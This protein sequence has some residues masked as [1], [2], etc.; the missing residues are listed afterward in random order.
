[1][2]PP[3]TATPGTSLNAA[4]PESHQEAECREQ[5]VSTSAN[6]FRGRISPPEFVFTPVATAPLSALLSADHIPKLVTVTAPAGY[7][8]TVFMSGLHKALSDREDRCIWIGLDDRDSDLSSLLYL[9]R[10]ALK[11]ADVPYDMEPPHSRENVTNQGTYLDGLL[12]HLSQ[13]D[14]N[15]VLFIDNLG[16]C[17]DTQLGMTLE[18]LIMESGPRLRLVFSTSSEL[19]IDIVRAKLE[20]GAMEL[21]A[22]QLCFDRRCTAQL[23]SSA[24]IPAPS[25]EE[26]DHIQAQT[27]GWPAAVRLLQILMAQVGHDDSADDA[28]R[29]RELKSF[30]GD[31]ND[32]A[33]VLTRRVLIGFERDFLEFLT[34]VAL[35][36]EFSVDLAAYATGHHKAEAWINTLV[37][38][39]ILIFPLDRSRRWYRLH[40]LLREYLLA[41]GR[42]RI[43]AER[44][45]TI[46][47]RA[48]QWHTN[49]G[50]D[51]TAIGIALDAQD[52]DLAKKLVDRVA[53]T[54][55]GDQGQMTPLVHWVDRLLAAGVEP[56]VE[57]HGWYVWALGDNL[58][59]E[60]AQQALDALDRRRGGKSLS[61]APRN[62]LSARLEFLRI[63]LGIYNDR[64]D[65]AHADAIAWLDK[66]QSPDALSTMTIASIAAVAETD[67]G[68]LAT[69]RRHIEIA[70]SAISRSVSGYG[71]AWE[72]IIHAFIDIAEARPDIADGHFRAMRPRVVEL[73]GTEANAVVIF[74]FIH[75]R[76][77]LDMGKA[78]AARPLAMRGLKRAAHH[79]IV[80]SVEHGLSACV[81]LWDGDPSSPFAPAAL[82]KVVSGY[83]ARAHRFLLASCARRLLRLGRVPEA[84]AFADRARHPLSATN[85]KTEQRMQMRGDWML[86]DVELLIANGSAQEALNAIEKLIKT[87]QH[88]GRQR[89]RIELCLAGVDANMRMGQ[90]KKA[91]RM[92]SLAILAAAPGCV[93]GPFKNRLPLIREMLISFKTRDFGFTRTSELQFLEALNIAAGTADTAAQNQAASQTSQVSDPPTPRE[94][95]LLDLLNQGQSNQQIAD[96]LS[97]S[98]TTVKWHLNNLYSKLGVKNRAAALAIARTRNLLSRQ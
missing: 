36:R 41:E 62:D 65:T 69:A 83:P 6:G 10:A 21:K 50:D 58:Q 43:P 31:H 61:E 89:D 16:F 85:Q 72:T 49:Q 67:R 5:T 95:E 8:K 11:K 73:I 12:G 57:A 42:Q 7:G 17:T 39:N 75:A 93:F 13:L 70:D 98:V 28:A 32:I 48:A 87:A 51:V 29:L 84:Q 66:A 23:L 60:R 40:T 71:L 1:M 96:R 20:V 30:G 92:L 88:D 37:R 2:M 76:I 82:E 33:Q 63:V 53:C 25:A 74:D 44:R 15:T 35:L 27:E 4:F 97:I 90:P 38:R 91:L 59:Y 9:L 3:I 14:G 80:T 47:K 68:E 34:E 81:D 18:R 19:P 26:L 22:A 86:M 45:C 78:D 46:L 77:L 56:S 55:A 64:L 79:G 54:V 52:F 94:T 24:G